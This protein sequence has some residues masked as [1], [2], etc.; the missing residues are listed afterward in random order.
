VVSHEL[1]FRRA[2]RHLKDIDDLTKGWVNGEHHTT[3]QETDPEDGRV[4]VYATAEQPPEDPFSLEIGEFLQSMRSGLDNL[5]YSLAR[6]FTDPLPDDVA[7]SSEFPIFGDRNR[8][9]N[10]GGGSRRFHRTTRA[11]DPKRGS[12]L[13]KVRGWAPG[14]QA[15]VE[16]LQPYHRGDAYERSP[17]WILH[18]LDNINRHRLLHT[19]FA[20]GGGFIFDPLKSHNLA[21]IGTGVMETIGGPITTDTLIARI[22]LQPV[23]PELEVHIEVQPALD[24]VFAAGTPIV[25]HESV[26]KTLLDIYVHVVGTVVPALTPFL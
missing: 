4:V 9:G 17:L 3:R 6:A 21:D 10:L 15:V 7:E 24:V 14:A 16:G 1:K 13:Y 18:E 11:G 20:Y 12:G 23:D 5:A 22:P 19:A 26:Y 2:F 25:E 8:K